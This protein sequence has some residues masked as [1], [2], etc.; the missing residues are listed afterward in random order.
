M[1]TKTIHMHKKMYKLKKKTKNNLLYYK[2]Q[3]GSQ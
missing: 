1:Q 2:N 3:T